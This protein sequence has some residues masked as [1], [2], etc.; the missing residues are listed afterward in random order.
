MTDLTPTYPLKPA[1]Q[2]L[3]VPPATS[4]TLN[5]PMGG[6]MVGPNA[7]QQGQLALNGANEQIL[8]GAATAPL[9]GIGVF[10][11]NAGDNTYDFRAGNPSANYI[12]WDGS[13]GILTVVGTISV[14]AGGTVGGFNVGADYIRDV[15]DSFGLA[16]TVT[17]GD[18]VRFWAGSNFASRA[19]AP[20]RVTESGQAHFENVVIGGTSVQ[21]TINDFGIYSFGDG[22]D[23]TAAFDGV[24]AVTGASRS[25][26][27]YTLTR[28]V[29]YTTMDVSTGVTI[30]P[31]GY[32]I[33]V[34]N[35]LTLNGTATIA[36][37]GNAG[38]AGGAA[39]GGVAGGSGGAALADGYLKGSVAGAQGATS[40]GRI[41]TDGIGGTTGTSTSNSLGSNGTGGG[42]GGDGSGGTK[43]SAGSGGT[44]T[45]S[46]VKLIANWHLAT[47]LDVSSSGSTVKFDNSAGAG[48]GASGGGGGGLAGGSGGGG[49]SAGGIIAIY[50]RSLVIGASASITANG[51]A[52]GNGGSQGS[53]PGGGGGGGAGGNGGQ[54]ILVYNTLTNSGSL[55]VAAGAGGSGGGPGGGGGSAGSSGTAGTAGTVR[56]FQ[57]SI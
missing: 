5:Q 31:A 48:G 53:S 37:N 20:F 15:A 25:G 7:I 50:A 57:I 52:G 56:Q 2:E 44:A 28:D 41:N 10:I 36:R 13:S 11:G 49:G 23:S 51:G 21:Y 34:R 9:T 17:V 43:G 4:D 26:S 32:R 18:D 19:S 29:Y 47:L 54:L 24:N 38:T 14:T 6:F 46:N 8:V 33:F 42:A 1:A 40:V 55:S 39:G 27:T 3:Y 45:A 12:Q 30:N 16:S 35:T 22:S